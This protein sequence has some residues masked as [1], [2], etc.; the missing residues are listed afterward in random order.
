MADSGPQPACIVKA[1]PMAQ[2]R[3]AFYILAGNSSPT[4]LGLWEVASTCCF[5]SQLLRKH[6]VLFGIAELESAQSNYSLM[7][8]LLNSELLKVYFQ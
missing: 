8:V 3:N 5:S 7:L 1:P 2:I 6:A 4:L